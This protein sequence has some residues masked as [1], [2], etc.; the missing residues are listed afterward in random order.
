ME[1]TPKWAS[2]AQWNSFGGKWFFLLPEISVSG[3]CLFRVGTQ[4]PL[5]LLSAGTPPGLNL[6][7][8]CECCYYLCA[9]LHA[10]SWFDWKILF[11]L[12]HLALISTFP[13]I[14]KPCEGVDGDTPVRTECPKLSSHC[15]VMSLCVSFELLQEETSLIWDKK[16]TEIW[17]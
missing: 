9:F 17:V 5:I 6:C 4:S 14:T 3:S 13:S 16:V 2:C 7:R 1:A 8:I 11:P 15:L 10:S 12:D